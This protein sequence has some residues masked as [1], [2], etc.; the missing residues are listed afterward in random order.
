MILI[1]FD[2]CTTSIKLHV[3]DFQVI[4]GQNLYKIKCKQCPSL[5]VPNLL[6]NEDELTIRVQ[7]GDHSWSFWQWEWQWKSIRI[8][9]FSSVQ[10]STKV[11]NMFKTFVFPIR[12]LFILGY[13]HWKHVVIFF[14]AQL[15][16]CILVILTV[17]YIIRACN[18]SQENSANGVWIWLDSEEEEPSRLLTI[19]ILFILYVKASRR[20][21][22]VIHIVGHNHTCSY[23]GT[24]IF[25]STWLHT[26]HIVILLLSRKNRAQIKKIWCSSLPQQELVQISKYLHSFTFG[27]R[28]GT[29]RHRYN[30]HVLKPLHNQSRS[31]CDVTILG[32]FHAVHETT[33]FMVGLIIEGCVHWIFFYVC[34]C[35]CVCVCIGLIW[36]VEDDQSCDTRLVIVHKYKL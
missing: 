20:I 22:T 35:V 13:A 12:I 32:E 16:C 8:V 1:R 14:V 27:S 11:L 6:P 15:T 10:A 25:V 21:H 2:T 9:F 5:T 4:F 34:V 3:D 17:Y 26:C 30:T 24:Y 36:T 28:F 31:W 18:I 33:S 29:V 7:L 23:L 19:F